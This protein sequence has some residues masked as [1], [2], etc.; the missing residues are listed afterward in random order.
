MIP[1]NYI[2]KYPFIVFYAYISMKSGCI[3]TFLVNHYCLIPGQAITS[4]WID[5]IFQTNGSQP[6]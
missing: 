6:H 5:E 4:L 1:K 2:Y 3:N